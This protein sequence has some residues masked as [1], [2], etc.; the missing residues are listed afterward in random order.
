MADCDIVKTV[1]AKS[2]KHYSENMFGISLAQ[3][4]I[5]LDEFGDIRVTA[6]GHLSVYDLIRVIGGQK[7][8]YNAWKRLIKEFPAVLTFCQDWKFKGER[9]RKTP[10]VNKEAA[11]KIVGLLPGTVGDKYRDAAAKLVLTYLEN[12]DQLAKAAI[13]RIKGEKELEEVTNK[14]LNKYL[15]TYHPLM[16]E[17]KKRN[18]VDT[19]YK[20]VN[21]VNTKTVMGKEPHLIKAERGGKTA[22]ENATVKELG[23]LQVLQD[24]QANG[25]Q[26]F[27]ADGHSEISKVIQDVA[28]DFEQLMAKYKI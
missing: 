2:I 19:T 17:I 28:S 18:G 16:G 1:G 21:T 8:P 13:D 3:E 25:L 4:S 7:D 27:N 11:L 6:D 15:S 23:Y 12:P 10:V 9:Q 22:R 5:V 24:I 14:A 20:H 26:K